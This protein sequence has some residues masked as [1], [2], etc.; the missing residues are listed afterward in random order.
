[1]SVIIG[2][3]R[4]HYWAMAL[5]LFFDM[6]V[7]SGVLYIVVLICCR[8]WGLSGPRRE[9]FHVLRERLMTIQSQ[10]DSV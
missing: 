9:F 6:F 5:H 8:A 3:E 2:V 4:G 7:L 1:M 10:S